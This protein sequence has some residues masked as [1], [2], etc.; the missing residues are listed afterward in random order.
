MTWGCSRVKCMIHFHKI[1]QDP[2]SDISPVHPPSHCFV[3]HLNEM[4]GLLN[5]VPPSS[6]HNRSTKSCQLKWSTCVWAQ[7][8]FCLTGLGFVQS[9]CQMNKPKWKSPVSTCV[10]CNKRTKPFNVWTFLHF[11]MSHL[12]H[13]AKAYTPLQ[14]KALWVITPSFLLSTHDRAVISR[15]EIVW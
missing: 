9:F 6:A 14:W 15:S 5:F 3:W 12:S 4:K 7:T 10:N 8:G 1:T 11:F 13:L 2:Q